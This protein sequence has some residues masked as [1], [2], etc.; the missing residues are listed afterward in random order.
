MRDDDA[1][2]DGTPLLKSQTVKVDKG[3]MCQQFVESKGYEPLMAIIVLCNAISIGF[4]IDYPGSMT[5]GQWMIF[6]CIFF[7]IFLVEVIIKMIAYGP[8]TYF[9]DGWN[10]FDFLVTFCAA[11]E[12]CA[13]YH[14]TDDRINSTWSKYVSGDMIQIMRLFRLLRMARIFKQLGVL[15]NSFVMSLQALSWI[16]VLSII[17]FFLCACV[18]TVFIGRKDW[19]PNVED[20]GVDR[21]TIQ[22]VRSRFSTIP[23]SMFALFE[24]MTLE[25]WVDYVRPLLASRA[26][27]VLLF[28][29]FI[30]VSSFFLLNLI[31]AVVVDRTLQAQ[32]QEMQKEEQT[33]D[34][35][36]TAVINQM[37]DVFVRLNGF[38]DVIKRVD[39]EQW[40]QDPA[41]V[42]NMAFLQ[43][44]T[45]FM[46]SMFALIDHDNDGECSIARMLSLWQ[47]CHAP[48]DTTSYVR[49]QINLAKRM[50]YSEKISM[51]ML[52]ALEEYF[53]K[54]FK[55][56]DELM[57]KESFLPRSVSVPPMGP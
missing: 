8:I 21:E 25:G 22:E 52:H 26:D 51:T 48:L 20:D 29:F 14:I 30:F 56:R 6:S 49:F 35:K 15:V 1:G 12:L 17:W 44:N 39:F 31:T 53:G 33:D 54:K 16:F 47:A 5:V 55:L 50:E 11:L 40:L 37:G 24:V 45:D 9:K 43:W 42:A 18:A 10:V 32:Q 34:I 38:K 13:T 19:L 36:E 4:Q 28:L 23:F 41:I 57:G 27:M 7:F 3:N 46:V 2:D